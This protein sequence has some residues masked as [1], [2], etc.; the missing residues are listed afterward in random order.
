LV[1]TVV[2]LTTLA[3]GPAALAQTPAPSPTSVPR[4]DGEVSGSLQAG[5]E[6]TIRV[7]AV[8]PGGWDALHLVEAVVVIEDEDAARLAYDIED[9]KVAVDGHEIV[10]GTGAVASG[11]LLRIRGSQV[12]VTTGGANL[13]LTATVEVLRTIP[14]D[15]RFR[16]S[17][18]G[19]RGETASIMRRVAETGS[20]GLTWGT[21]VAAVVL[22]LLAGGFVGNLYASHRRPPPRLSVYGTIQRRLEVERS[23]TGERSR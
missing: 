18:I 8:M 20:G 15:A 17:V 23:D 9:T 4:L 3:A 16:L 7:D 14:S 21:V 13:S 6:L 1:V 22:A 12:V 2:A 11:E 10:V 5:E 19:D